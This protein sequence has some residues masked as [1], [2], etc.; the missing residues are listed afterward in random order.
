MS[1]PRYDLI[2]HRVVTSLAKVFTFG[3]EKH[4]ERGWLE[5]DSTTNHLDKA[6]RHINEYQHGKCVDEETG[7]SPLVHACANLMMLVDRE[8]DIPCMK[9][10]TNDP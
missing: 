3:A 9:G 2:P 6:L 1:K 5:K 10:K 8:I 4:S 7:E